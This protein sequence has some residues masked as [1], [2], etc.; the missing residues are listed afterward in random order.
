MYEVTVSYWS[1]HNRVHNSNKRTHYSDAMALWRR[2]CR[3]HRNAD[4]RLMAPDG[5]VMKNKGDAWPS[6]YGSTEKV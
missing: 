1:D 3:T 4:V 6:E 5:H 2:Q